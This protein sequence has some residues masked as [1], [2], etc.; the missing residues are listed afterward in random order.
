MRMFFN[1]RDVRLTDGFSVVTNAGDPVWTGR[2]TALPYI[3]PQLRIYHADVEGVVYIMVEGPDEGKVVLRRGITT[4]P[5]YECIVHS[6]GGASV[7]QFWIRTLGLLT[8]ALSQIDESHILFSTA[9][10]TTSS[11]NITSYP[12]DNPSGLTVYLHVSDEPFFD[13][14]YN[15][16]LFSMYEATVTGI[17]K[18]IDDSRNHAGAVA[19]A[20]LKHTFVVNGIQQTL[21]N[22][23][24]CELSVHGSAAVYLVD[25]GAVISAES[26]RFVISSATLEHPAKFIYMVP[27]SSL[28][29]GT[30]T[31][32]DYTYFEFDDQHQLIVSSQYIESYRQ[33]LLNTTP[34]VVVDA[35]FRKQ[36][37]TTAAASL[38]A[39]III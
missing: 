38:A 21:N 35:L 28:I 6:F 32:V 13:G 26:R 34:K 27:T 2:V 19:V 7:D 18:S 37:T 9:P 25:I 24:N 1:D 33:Y 31:D 30:L 36:I 29:N 12:I 8:S 11:A 17:L 5:L 4:L 23:P 16:A 20:P 39:G 22:H 3:T 14:M 15:S 10:V